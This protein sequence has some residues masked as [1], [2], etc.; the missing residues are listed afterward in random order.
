MP[1][2]LTLYWFTN[3]VLSTAQQ[4]Y[5]KATVKVNIPE[6]PTNV[7]SSTTPIVKPKEERIKAVTGECMNE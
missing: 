7:I 4:L 3:N 5:L 1:S 6:A 2:G